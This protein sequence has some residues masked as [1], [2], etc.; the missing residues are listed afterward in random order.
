[1]GKFPGAGGV[2][3]GLVGGILKPS[4]FRPSTISQTVAPETC[5]AKD[6]VCAMKDTVHALALP[7]RTGNENV[8]D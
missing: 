7:S 1:M 6:T 3:V 8:D 4:I 5:A 2:A